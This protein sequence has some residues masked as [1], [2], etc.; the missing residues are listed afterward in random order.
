MEKIDFAALVKKPENDCE[1]T[2][3]GQSGLRSSPLAYKF[4]PDF[5][6]VDQDKLLNIN[7]MVY[8]VYTG[9]QKKDI[10]GLVTKN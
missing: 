3:N 1:T 10:P 9:L 7:G 6:Q 4:Q 8:M 2:R 5:G